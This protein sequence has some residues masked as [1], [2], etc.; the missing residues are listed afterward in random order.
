MVTPTMP[1]ASVR[2]NHHYLKISINFDGRHTNHTET[3]EKVCVCVCVRQ[4]NIFVIIN[5]FLIDP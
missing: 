4:C 5:L 1:T 3:G 2:A